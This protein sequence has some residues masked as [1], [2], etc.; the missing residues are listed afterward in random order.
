VEP[1]VAWKIVI[2][3][4]NLGFSAAHFITLDGAI[5]PLH[6]HNYGVRVEVSG[7]LSPDSIVLDFVR[8]KDIVRGLCKEWDHRFLMPLTNPLLQVRDSGA[9]A[10]EIA[11]EDGTRYVLPRSTVVALAVDNVT[12]ERLAERLAVRIAEV[13]SQ[14]GMSA[15]LRTI[16]VGIS[17]TEMQ[18]ASY[19]LELPAGALKS[20]P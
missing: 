15:G 5:E 18:T 7:D 19:M 13:L 17:E 14:R 1:A 3:R 8:F 12:T 6:G 10:W 4:G 2:E 9:G 20:P 11:A 16:E